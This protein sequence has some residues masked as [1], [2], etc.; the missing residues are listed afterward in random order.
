MSIG[1]VRQYLGSNQADHRPAALL[2]SNADL[3][4]VTWWGNLSMGVYKVM[5]AGSTITLVR[6]GRS[7]RQATEEPDLRGK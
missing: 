2:D 1:S 7:V 4:E 6:G 3:L 5:C